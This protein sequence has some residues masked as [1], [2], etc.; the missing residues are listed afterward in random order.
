MRKVEHRTGAVEEAI[1]THAALFD[2]PTQAV[3]A[4]TLDGRIVYWSDT[5][6]R[7]Y[8]WSSEEVLGRDIL[9]V[10]PS[11]TTREQAAEIMSRLREGQIWS[12]E[13]H[14]RTRAGEGFCAH[15]RDVPVRDDR[16]ELIGIVGISHGA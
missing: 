8:G 3:V 2:I 6:A 4:T 1:R 15:V 9:E 16:G 5:A 7:M 14:V 13:F 11:E 12:G 10:T